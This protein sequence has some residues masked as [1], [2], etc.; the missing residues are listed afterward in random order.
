[1]GD[2]VVG[3]SL[4]WGNMT[5]YA[6]LSRTRKKKSA[7][8]LNQEVLIKVFQS[9][10]NKESG[11]GQTTVWSKGKQNAHTMHGLVWQH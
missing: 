2:A 10:Q 3:Q 4:V 7:P 9:Q 6:Q 11:G 8:T 1:M 5:N